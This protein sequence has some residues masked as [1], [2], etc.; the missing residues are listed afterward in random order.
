METTPVQ[1]DQATSPLW[2]A[3]GWYNAVLLNER[4]MSC[5][6]AEPSSVPDRSKLEQAQKKFQRW[7]DQAPFNTGTFFTQRL[8]MDG[9]TEEDLLTLLGEPLESLQ[10][11]RSQPYPPEWL[12]ELSSALLD[13]TPGEDIAR[14]FAEAMPESEAVA[15]LLPFTSLMRP[16]IARLRAGIEKLAH[17]SLPFDQQRIMELLLPN[18][19]Q[20]IMPK[21]SKT[22]VL[23]LNIA[24]LRGQLQGE[25][26]QERF[27]SY[28]QSLC[29]RE[30]LIAFLQEYCV[31]ARQFLVA[32]DRWVLCSLELVSR[33]YADWDE[34]RALF[35]PHSEPGPLVEIGGSAGDTHRGG[36][37]VML[38][39]FRSGLQLVYK[40]KS[41]AIDVHFQQ[42]LQWLNEQGEGPAFRTLKLLDR[43]TYGWSEFVT[44]PECSSEEEVKRFFV[45]QGRYLALLYA[46]DASDFHGENVLAA[47]EHPVLVD[48][49]ALFHPRWILNEDGMAKR[50]AF[51]ILDH[52][53]RRIALLPERFWS[54]EA[55]E[56]VDLSGLGSGE[57][58][59]PHPVARWEDVASDE[60]KLVR[61]HIE[62]RGGNNLPRLNGRSMQAVDYLEYI[63]SGF[64]AMYHFLVRHQERIAR[65]YLSLFAQDEIRF[66]A[67]AT[68]IYGILLTESFHPNMLR[69]ALKR[70]RFFDG[71]W[72]EVEQQP[73]LARLIAAERA[74]LWQG[75]IPMF[76]T[77]PAS[78][79]LF[80]SRG[81]RIPDFFATSS[82]DMVRQRLAALDEEDLE[83]QIWLIRA[84]FASVP[85]TALSISG[86]QPTTGQA[87]PFPERERLLRAAQV[88][89][90]RLCA[91]A[92]VKDDMADWIGLSFVMDRDWGVAL[93]GADLYNGL[94]GII[95]FLSYL[96]A[97]TENTRYTE[98]ASRALK[99]FSYELARLTAYPDR[100][101]VGGFNGWGSGIYLFTQLAIL[102]R[103]ST[104]LQEAERLVQLFPDVLK[105]DERYDL[106]DGSAGGIASLLSL[107][108]M[109]P[110]AETL[111][112]AERCGDHLLAQA[113]HSAQG[114]GWK[115]LRQEVP[116]AGFARGTAGIV[117]SLLRLSEVSGQ[118]RFRQAALAA[119]AYERSL[120]VPEVCNWRDL[121]KQPGSSA[122]AQRYGMSW[123]HGAPGIALGR[124]ASLRYLD[125]NTLRQE[126][127]AA[128]VTTSEEGF[129]YSH[130]QIGSNHSLAHGDAGNLEALL[131]A[132]RMLRGPLVE[133]YSARLN[134]VATNLLRSI[135][136]GT[137]CLGTPRNIEAPGLM[138]GLAGIGY[139]LLRLA[140]PGWVPSV[141]LLEPPATTI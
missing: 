44:T 120:Y 66:V 111:A 106:V 95:L 24:R 121:R 26:P 112:M 92:I 72:T 94:P 12:V 141:L 79:D 136:A 74:D 130:E 9:L 68:R 58:L 140:D 119:L 61:E 38:L 2:Q 110:T 123:A 19:V 34:L 15:F 27:H 93:A 71:L 133:E 83:R 102:W 97:L 31:L 85:L 47:G 87:C 131:Q 84:S 36:R 1:T 81:E 125:D 8:E 21:I 54:T 76:T 32:I 18:F 109:A 118:Q 20:Q 107:Y 43:Q 73:L 91:S 99:T 114:A 77:R 37:S 45:R 52:S 113:Q 35:S 33:L 50:P 25:T 59:S 41:L 67:R 7:R 39:K 101:C 57:G 16:G 89:G 80:T 96:G 6:R 51:H 128:L 86:G 49:E 108:A 135:E 56:G 4:S 122:Q 48:L 70:E 134:V 65:E 117:W 103:D 42:L 129:G 64:R 137:I 10:A 28:I 98:L 29:Q 53:V 63:V 138:I 13:P 14:L 69:D 23:E 55:F 60:M 100:Y 126:I 116:L 105:K 5:L 90:D 11:R 17:G 132:G 78:C 88:L 115:T 40:P 62:M 46:L 3:P 30:H 82:L 139:A 124:L 127:T 75:D 22:L 104:L